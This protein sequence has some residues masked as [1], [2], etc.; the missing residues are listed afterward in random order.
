MRK[1][2]LKA[3][4]AAFAAVAMSLAFAATGAQADP[5]FTPDNDDFAGVGSDTS[6]FLLNGLATAYN[7]QSPAPTRR[8]ASWDATG[9]SPIIVQAGQP[10]PGIARPN[11]SGAG[12]TAL[13]AAA[14]SPGGGVENDYVDYA[15]HSGTPGTSGTSWYPIARDGL[16]IAV[17]RANGDGS[18]A[19]NA[20]ASLVF[21]VA[22]LVSI[23]QCQATANQWSDFVAGASTATINPLLP[24]PGSGTRKFFLEQIGLTEA[25]VITKSESPSSYCVNDDPQE[26]DPAP[27][28][29]DANAIAPF[30]V[31]RYNVNVPVVGGQ[32]VIALRTTTGNFNVSRLLYNV[33]KTSRAATVG[34]AF[35]STSF[36]CTSATAD[37]TITSNGFTVL[38]KT[39]AAGS[40]GVPVI[41][42]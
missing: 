24:Q 1:T 30:S 22:R 9:T 14:N 23:Y 6:Q 16:A 25:Q 15:R 31:G 19:T 12:L 17:A 33:I 37:S 26:H 7:A 42:P 39:A 13:V 2:V 32:K 36:L 18:P 40:C 34:A 35:N 10:A 27:I 29:A 38:P 4:G 21:T 20:P 41:I 3:A 5:S 11:G 8:L 28:N